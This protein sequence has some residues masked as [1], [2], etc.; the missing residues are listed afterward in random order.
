[1]RCLVSCLVWGKPGE[2]GLGCTRPALTG[3]LSKLLEYRLKLLESYDTVTQAASLQN[4]MVVKSD[5][6]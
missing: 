4:E 1:M 3:D 2:A 5:L 6:L